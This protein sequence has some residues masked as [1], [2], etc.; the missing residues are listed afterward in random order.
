MAGHDEVSHGTLERLVG[1]I[2]TVV[3]AMAGLAA[4]VFGTWINRSFS[5]DLDVIYGALL[6][7]G[8]IAAW[9]RARKHSEEDAFTALDAWWVTVPAGMLVAFGSLRTDPLLFA[10]LARW[11][12]GA[13]VSRLPGLK[14]LLRES[15]TDQPAARPS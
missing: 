7:T 5:G 1:R 13:L 10:A 3:T 14:Q 9:L 8:G 15:S 6:V 11:G 12:T 4:G 2:P